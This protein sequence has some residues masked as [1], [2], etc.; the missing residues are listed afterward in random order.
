MEELL[1][2]LILVTSGSESEEW[3]EELLAREKPSYSVS[4][5]KL[6]RMYKKLQ[7]DQFVSF[8]EA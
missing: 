4:H 6:C 3:S 7:R 1:Q 8:A 2:E 5:K